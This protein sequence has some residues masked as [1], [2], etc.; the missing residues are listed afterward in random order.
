MILL[1]GV[2]TDPVLRYFFDQNYVN[3]DSRILF[4]N[5]DRIGKDIFISDQGWS[6]PLGGTLLH[7]EVTAVYNRMLSEHSDPACF[8]LNWLLDEYYPNVINRPKDTLVNFS[9]LWQL[10]FAKKAGFDIPKTAIYANCRLSR[11]VSGI[12]KS[13]SSKRSI[14]EPVKKNRQKMVYEPVVFQ[15][16]KGRKNIRVHLLEGYY[17]AQE[18]SSNRVDYRYDLHANAARRCQI[19]LSLFQKVYDLAKA[20]N[21]IFSG[22]DFILINDRYYFL[23]M[24]PSPGYAYFEKQLKGTPISKMLYRVLRRNG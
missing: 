9:K 21:L 11:H 20:F 3:R 2:K 15:A 18:V 16:D 13:I 14:V 6:F 22:I 23:E 4:I 17:V 24:N 5:T 7:Q 10:E 1:I 19:P 8:F 12:Y